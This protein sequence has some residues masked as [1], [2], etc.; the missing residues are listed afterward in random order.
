MCS[1]FVGRY[2]GILLSLTIMIYFEAPIIFL[3][4]LDIGLFFGHVGFAA[5]AC[6]LVIHAQQN[7]HPMVYTI[8]LNSK[9]VFGFVLQFAFPQIFLQSVHNIWEYAGIVLC[10]IG[11]V[12]YV[13]IDF[14]I[15]QVSSI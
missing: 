5:C 14:K 2:L 8:L 15:K 12:S 1:F 10:V 4:N 11:V 9:V 7:L 6:I 3:D 13:L